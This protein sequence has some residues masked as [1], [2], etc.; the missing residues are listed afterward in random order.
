MTIEQ[1]IEVPASHRITLDV[2][3]QIPAGKVILSFTPAGE[4]AGDGPDFEGECPICAK[5]RDP[6]TG[7][8]R[9]NAGVMAGMKEV[10]DMLSGKIPNTMKSFNSLD[11]M[12]ADLDADD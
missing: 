12:L 11:E 2:P 4:T 3:P 1:T 10:D 7:N 9:Y 5:H 6:V 8:P